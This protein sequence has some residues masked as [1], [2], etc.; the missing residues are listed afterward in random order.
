[1][2]HVSLADYLVTVHLHMQEALHTQK[3]P[4]KCS[5]DWRLAVQVLLSMNNP[6]SPV[7][8]SKA[9]YALMGV[10]A[11]ANPVGSPVSQACEQQARTAQALHEVS[12]AADVRQASMTQE[13]QQLP[14]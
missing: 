5:D 7:E 8:V 1:M 12:T 3:E 2:L 9:V 14:A 10:P 6:D 4:I 13:M 11:P